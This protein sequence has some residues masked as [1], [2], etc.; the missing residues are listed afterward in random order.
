MKKPLLLFCIFTLLL[1]LPAKHAEAQFWKKLFKKEQ[2]K[3]KPPVKK[4][5]VKDK[6]VVTK[7][8]KKKE[9]EYP[10]SEKKSR[11]RVDVL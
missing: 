8:N 11:Y 7:P 4:P 2:P 9:I 6:P 3:R 10:A 1:L 5:P